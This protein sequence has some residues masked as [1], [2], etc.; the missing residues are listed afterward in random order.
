MDPRAQT[1]IDELKLQPHPEGGFYREIHRSSARVQP[2]DGRGTRSALTTIYFLL[3]RGAHSRW[4]RVRSDEVWHLYEGGPLELLIAQPDLNAYNTVTLAAASATSGPVHT[5]PAAW[6]QAA[7]PTANFALVGCTVGPGFEFED[8]SFLR[9]SPEL[10]ARLR[11][12]NVDWSTL[13]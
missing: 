10:A 11:Q 9:D 2:D 13:L 5:V 6:W 12:T 8:F 1:L 7:R 4:H 3:P